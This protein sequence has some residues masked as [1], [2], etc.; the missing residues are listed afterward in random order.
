MWPIIGILVVTVG[1]IILEVPTMIQ[2]KLTKELKVFS[3]LLLFGV[4][5]SIAESLNLNIPNPADWITNIYRPFTDLLLNI[6]K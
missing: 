3:F 5:L 2:K 6:L 1:I 4:I